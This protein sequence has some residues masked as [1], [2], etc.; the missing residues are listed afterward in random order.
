M[1]FHLLDND[2]PMLR[3]RLWK[4]PRLIKNVWLINLYATQLPSTLLANSCQ[5][6][7]LLKSI[8]SFSFCSS[9]TAKSKKVALVIGHSGIWINATSYLS[10]HQT[11]ASQCPKQ[12]LSN[13]LY[14]YFNTPI[15]EKTGSC[16]EVRLNS[17]RGKLKRT[18]MADDQVDL[19][20]EDIPGTS[21]IEEEKEKLPVAQLKVWLKCRRINQ[22]VNKKELLER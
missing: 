5:L 6:H 13:Q 7:K 14:T 17:P 16:T 12:P 18:N 22:I 19:T 9:Y 2:K 21:F 3:I 8:S 4:T 1:L 11:I 10:E 15:P 20:P